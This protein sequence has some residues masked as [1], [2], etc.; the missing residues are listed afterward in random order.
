[1]ETNKVKIIV[2]SELYA[3]IYEKEI[4]KY[5]LVR[6]LDLNMSDAY[7]PEEDKAFIESLISSFNARGI[8]NFDNLCSYE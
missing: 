3:L 4:N 1:M 2:K 6:S 8:V 5:F 7:D